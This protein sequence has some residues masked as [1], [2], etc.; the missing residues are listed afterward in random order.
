MRQKGIAD[1][2]DRL[3]IKRIITDRSKIMRIGVILDV[4]GTLWDSSEKVAASFAD[5][6]SKFPEITEP[7]T[8]ETILSLMGLPM[9]AF[10]DYFM[11]DLPKEKAT[12]IM[13]QCMDCEIDYL[14]D[15]LPPVFDGVT[16]TIRAL[17]DKYQMFIVSNAQQG[18]I[19]LCMKSG[20]FADVI[21]D[22]RCFGDNLLPKEGNIRLIADKYH[23]ERFFYVGDIQG[24]Y[25]STMKA[26]GEFIHAAYGFGTINTQVPA[27]HD[28]KELP[29]CLERILG[30]PESI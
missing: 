29:A 12:A 24:D 25:D 30:E 20:G 23:L 26:H 8:R 13:N 10:M 22:Y 18:Y 5:T 27:I 21:T 9:T 4:D 7:C 2:I 11:G 3:G 19:E 16:E 15:H 28:I 6:L 14:K 17:A 1:K